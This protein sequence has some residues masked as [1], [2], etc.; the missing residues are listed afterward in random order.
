MAPGISLRSNGDLLEITLRRPER[1]NA[2]GAAEWSLLEEAFGKAA[3]SPDLD[4]V[5]LR[6]EGDV[7]CAGVDLELVKSAGDAPGGLI[8]LIERNGAIL[9]KFELL[10][11]IT[12]AALNGPAVGIGVHLA[13]CADVVLGLESAYLS[14]PEARLGIPDVLHYA[15][16]ESRLGRSAALA[17]CL[18]GER[19][20]MRDAVRDGLA[21]GL[22]R[23]G[24][25]L[26]ERLDECLRRLREVPKAVR[27]Q[28]KRFLNE[29]SRRSA[30]DRQVEAVAALAERAG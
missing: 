12:L 5:V 30:P 8:G 1:R 21:G 10:P 18:L 15:L 2:L 24:A 16:L 7:F 6:G 22:A 3:A 27:R 20:S 26:S 23:S 14:I 13:L 4:Y 9:R 11:Q 17:L 28:M 19:M 25:E 29:T